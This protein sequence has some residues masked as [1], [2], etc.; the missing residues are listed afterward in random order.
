MLLHGRI[1]HGMTYVQEVGGGGA[2]QVEVLG[3]PGGQV[4]QRQ[5]RP[6]VRGMLQKHARK[7]ERETSTYAVFTRKVG[8]SHSKE[9]QQH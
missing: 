6:R 8:D 4:G 1:G 9:Q 3:L 7:R 5:G 2:R